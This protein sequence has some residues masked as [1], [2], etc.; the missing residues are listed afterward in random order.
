MHDED[1]LPNPIPE[2]WDVNK[3]KNA[4]KT[5]DLN[6]KIQTLV[7]DFGSVVVLSPDFEGCSGVPKSQANK[8][9]K[10]LAALDHFD[11]IETK[12]IPTDLADAIRT[13]Y[14]DI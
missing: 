3:R 11:S 10:P 12:N 14:G 6:T 5:F 8:K 2:A 13:V 9:G 4:K 7:G 1:P